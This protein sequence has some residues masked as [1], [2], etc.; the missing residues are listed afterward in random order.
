[1]RRRSGK[2]KIS[3]WIMFI[4]LLICTIIVGYYISAACFEGATVFT[5]YDNFTQNI[6]PYPFQQWYGNQ[7]TLKTIGICLF[8]YV[9]LIIYYMCSSTTFRFGEEQGSAKFGD[10]KQYNKEL[11]DL[12][13]DV[14]DEKNIEVGKG[15]INTRNTRVS[16]HLSVSLDTR[17]TD[18]NNNMLVIGGSGAGKTFRFVLPNLMM[19]QGSYIVT[20][21][22]GEIIRKSAGYAK[23]TGG[24]VIKSL[25]L[26]NPKQM[27]RSTRYN[28]FKYVSSDEDIV[29]LAQIY[30]KATEEENSQ[31]GEQFWTDMAELLLESLF[32]YTYYEGYEVDGKLQKNFRAVMALSNMLK[33]ESDPYGNRKPNE[34]DKLMKK[35]D[36][37]HPAAL[38]YFKAMV[39]AADTVR[40]IV[41]VL[42]SRLKRLQTKAVLDLL[43]EDEIELDKIGVRKTIL[44]CCIPDNDKTYNF[45]ISM[46]YQQLFDQLYYQADFIYNGELPVHVRFLIDE[47]ANVKLP[48]NF[49]E[50]LSTMRSRNISAVPIIQNLAQIKKIYKDGEWETIPGN[51]DTVIYLGGNE[52][53]THKWIAEEMIGNQTIHKKGSSESKGK[54]GSVSSSEDIM[55]RQLM[56]ADE[57]RRMKRSKCLVFI[58]GRHVILDDKIKTNRFFAWKTFVSQSKQYKFDMRLERVNDYLQ[59]SQENEIM[60]IKLYSESDTQLLRKTDE[61]TLEEYKEEVEI[62]KKIGEPL[63]EKPQKQIITCSVQELL[64]MSAQKEET[65]PENEEPLSVVESIMQQYEKYVGSDED[66]DDMSDEFAACLSDETTEEEKTNEGEED[67]ADYAQTDDQVDYMIPLL[68]AGYGREQAMTLANVI[69]SGKISLEQVLQS[70]SANYSMEY[71][72]FMLEMLMDDSI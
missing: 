12:N 63:P 58:N 14:N 22:K 20:D 57:V 66:E 17:H 36:P 41:S 44:Y 13:N 46:I 8:I 3:E 16:E 71:L 5:W 27:K 32:Y 43:S 31:K 11:A 21:P 7:Y 48:D 72:T 30:F 42:H 35:L 50:L 52:T 10:V 38:A 9:M 37:Q 68:N 60:K 4:L 64:W 34:I 1:M 39:G 6:L 47:F 29:K 59:M 2:V 55:Q 53:S 18:I 65:L 26:L 23:N 69:K 45:I 24:Y 15:I 70:F 28:P 25:I 62:A 56:Y 61:R 33:V 54:Q 67:A 49:L 19:M 51:C 40:S